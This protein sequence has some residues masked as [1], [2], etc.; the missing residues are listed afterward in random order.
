VHVTVRVFWDVTLHSL[1]DRYQCLSENWFVSAVLHSP[2]SHQII[3]LK[4]NELNS[5]LEK[6]ETMKDE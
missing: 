3:I 1:L 4:M 5:F 6:P 2:T